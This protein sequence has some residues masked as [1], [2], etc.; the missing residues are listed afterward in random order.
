M[1]M[2]TQTTHRIL[3]GWLILAL[4]LAQG[5]RVC[6]HTY[7]PSNHPASLGNLSSIHL[8]SIFDDQEPVVATA[9]MQDVPV[10]SLLKVFFADP[11]T[12]IASLVFLVALLMLPYVV[13]LVRPH[14]PVLKPPSGYYLT[15]PLRAPPR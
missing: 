12:A 6:I 11:I 3:I 4:L 2:S 1:R 7:D 10:F 5:L 13:R 8:E 14:D 9:N 15:P